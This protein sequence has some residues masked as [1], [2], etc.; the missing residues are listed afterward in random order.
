MMK[1]AYVKHSAFGET[2]VFKCFSVTEGFQSDHVK[3]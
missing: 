3:G 1:H 2:H